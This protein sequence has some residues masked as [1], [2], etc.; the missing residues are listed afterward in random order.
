MKDVK[1]DLDLTMRTKSNIRIG[2]TVESRVYV[3]AKL[4]PPS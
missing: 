2:Y 4:D 3:L 1:N